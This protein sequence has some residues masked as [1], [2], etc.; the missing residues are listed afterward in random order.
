MLNISV[1]NSILHIE[2]P[3]NVLVHTKKR[4]TSFENFIHLDLLRLL[5]DIPGILEFYNLAM[6][7]VTHMAHVKICIANMCPRLGS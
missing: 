3:S 6:F 4:L 5:Q 7:I 2:Y 1:L